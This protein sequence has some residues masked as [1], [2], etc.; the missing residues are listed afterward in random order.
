V[1]AIPSA[2]T[3]TLSASAVPTL[4]RSRWSPVLVVLRKADERG[5]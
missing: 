2:G 5:E 1:V 4:A 3:G